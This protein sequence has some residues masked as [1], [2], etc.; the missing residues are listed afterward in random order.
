M[1]QGKTKRF[2]GAAILAACCLSLQ[3]G[4][5]NSGS[6]RTAAA[7]TNFRNAQVASVGSADTAAVIR[8]G[9]A[10]IVYD[11]AA[12]SE[13]L[14]LKGGS[15]GAGWLQLPE[16]FSA[17]CREGFSL[18]MRYQLGS[19][20]EN[21]TRLFQFATVPLG[22]GNTSGYNSPDISMDL[23]GSNSP[24]RTSVFAGK[25]SAAADADYR[26]LFTV[27]I[28]RDTDW[29]T[30]TA[31]YSAANSAQYYLDGKAVSADD[32][33]GAGKLKAACSALFSQNMLSSY[34]YNGIG[35]SLYSDNDLTAKIDDVKFYD[36]ALTGTQAAT[37]P[38]D[39]VY[40]Y[41]FAEDTVTEGAQSAEE[42]SSVT[43]NGTAVSS[44]PS[45]QT[46]SPDGTLTAKIWHDAAGRYYYSVTKLSGGAEAEVV[47]PSRLGFSTSSADLSSGFPAEAP[48]CTITEFDETYEVP[49]GKHV[50]IRNH[51][52]E[53]VFP[54]KKG[55]SILTVTLRVYDDGVGVRYALNHGATISSEA[56]QVMFPSNSTFWGNWPNNTYEFDYVELPK[57]RGNE[58]NATYSL[59][60]TGVINNKYW[61]TV[62]EANVFNEPDPYCAGSLQFEGNY[63]SLRF[64]GG[65]KVKEIKMNSAFH[66]PWR[67]VIIGDSLN[68][69]ASSD[70]I[71]NLNPP[72][73]IE[74]TGWIKAGK[75]AWSW[76]SSGGDSPVEYHMQKEY[77][78]FA[79]E[80]GWDN[81]CVDFGWALWDD[82][83]AKIKEL[84]DYGKE[85]G[86]DI[87]LWYGVNNTGHSGYKDSRGNPAYPYYSLL[88]EATIKR[89]FERVSG[90]GVKG[91]K[92]DYYES[93]TQETMRQ[94]YLCMDIAAKNHMM[95]LFHGCTVPRGE[96]RTYPNVISYEAVNGAEYYKWF[97]SPKLEN[98]VSYTFTRCVIGSADF[99]PP[100]IPV[101]NSEATAGFALADAV[102]IESGVQHFAHSVYTYEG[103][104][105]LPLL[106]DI[107]VKW[108]DMHVLDGRPMQ[109]NVTARR[110]GS[111]WYIGCST[112]SARK[113]SIKIGELI[114][115]DTDTYNAYLFCDN[116][117]GSSLVTSVKTGLTKDDTI[118]LSLLAKGGAVIKLTK[119]TM[120]LSTPYSN[121]KFYEA[122][123]AKIQGKASVTSGKD[124]KYCSNEAYV[125][126]VGGSGNGVTFENIS[127]PEEGD[128]ELRIYYVSGEPRTLKV[129]VNG[130][131]AQKIDNCYA[132]KNDWSGIRAVSATVHLKA[133]SN[134][135]KLYNDAGNAPSIDRIALALPP[136]D[137]L[138]GDLDGNKKIDARD[139]TLMKQGLLTG[140]FRDSYTEKVSD[141]NRDGKVDHADTVALMN[142]LTAS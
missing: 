38:N 51:Y 106:N 76:W 43:P 60:Y 80:N 4:L 23:N 119:G 29:H 108:D 7:V 69:M 33:E 131:F 124:A 18:S 127:A 117:D 88:D 31:V 52:N 61:V 141:F 107:P 49:T 116:N 46:A 130:S 40:C 35:H 62:S 114:G 125:G 140:K 6:L 91:V 133:G 113:V 41:T 36:Y 92:V 98:R 105:A 139:L 104:P 123:N 26:A 21:Y 109:F 12:K 19:N 50:V 27:G 56:T 24:F 135:I 64:K 22:T 16:V 89:E 73:V 42:E 25:G 90:L 79:A 8:G 28:E 65:V 17:G 101:F 37:L 72:S 32:S 10:E 99:T 39:P 57:E 13:V 85:K 118:D 3:A 102:T 55:D 53:L 45:L 112:I 97:T 103:N 2:R 129:D 54:L 20:A 121:Y 111:D 48:E 81:V 75:A 142:F 96:S 67:A 93:D 74:D 100:C 128:Y 63:H 70:L 58:T 78:D 95:V 138:Y 134:T 5:L 126:Y 137:L 84:C 11:T 15:F 86:I 122:E 59:P 9:S 44:F 115:N 110:S 1:N 87:W 83:E 66:T 94:M 34:T 136:D 14:S 120:N 30:L 77:I 68:Q 82:S 71:L 47:L 132:N